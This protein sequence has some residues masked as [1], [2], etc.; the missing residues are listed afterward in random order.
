[1]KELE[2][3]SLLQGGKY[4]IEKVLGQGGF[5]ITYEGVQTALDRRVAI[6]EFFM[7]DYCDRQTGTSHVS[8]PSEG[9][10]IMVDEFKV[11]F[12]KEA[13]MIAR[14]EGA[15]HIVRIYDIFEE[16]DTAYYV[17]EFIGGGSLAQVIK[18]H[19]R[20]SEAEA[21]DYVHQ[22]GEALA[23]LHQ[24]DTLHLDVKPSNVLINQKGEAVL[25]D[26]GVSKHYDK[27][28]SQTSSSPVG[29]STGFAPTE[30]YQSGGVQQFTPATDVYALGATLYNMLTGTEPP[31]ASIVFEDGLPARPDQVSPTVWHAIEQAMQPR[32]KDRTQSVADFM[33][34]IDEKEDI[35]AA[36]VEI[37]VDD[38]S[39]PVQPV[40]VPLTPVSLAPSGQGA[41]TQLSPR[42]VC[43]N[44][45]KDFSLVVAF[46]GT[47]AYSLPIAW[48]T[49]MQ[50]Q[51]WYPQFL[52]QD[53]LMLLVFTYGIMKL[54]GLLRRKKCDAPLS[55]V[56]ALPVVVPLSA[57]VMYLVSQQITMDWLLDGLKL[58][59]GSDSIET[60]WTIEK[61]VLA[62]FLFAGLGT[63]TVRYAVKMRPDTHAWRWAGVVLSAVLFLL[64]IFFAIY[65][66]MTAVRQWISDSVEL[67]ER[68]VHHYSLAL[69]VL[70]TVLLALPVA[71]VMVAVNKRKTKA[72]APKP[73]L[74]ARVLMAAQ[75]FFLSHLLVTI[76]M[77]GILVQVNSWSYWPWSF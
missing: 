43:T 76:I 26:F 51:L 54:Y 12:V 40:A 52:T 45:Y 19:G 57:T 68:G 73:S 28:G 24:H 63:I 56:D 71:A 17:M 6:K 4:R 55:W 42:T 18:Q 3:G 44:K 39:E 9:L 64:L 58:I 32:R 72:M 34:M 13:Q 33:A 23:W 29:L 38:A 49:I 35:A 5:G 2:T 61:A 62:L 8:V 60:L 1:M 77:V 69:F 37:V 14:M 70:L 46:G 67:Q 16:N 48:Q 7:K 75:L 31:E 22:I 41:A 25:I 36:E 10:R 11:K 50:K 27:S 30:Q 65:F 74:Q 15:P 53:L 21:V 59:T 47:V 20:L 66:E